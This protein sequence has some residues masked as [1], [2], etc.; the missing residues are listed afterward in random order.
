MLIGWAVCLLL[1]CPVRVNEDC[2]PSH[3]SDAVQ[4]LLGMA[5][6]HTHGLY[7]ENNMEDGY[8]EYGWSELDVARM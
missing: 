6:T 8:D 4:A 7:S 2:S 5:A 3:N 1:L